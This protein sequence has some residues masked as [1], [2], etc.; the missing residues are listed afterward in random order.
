MESGS[1]WRRV[2]AKGKSAENTALANTAYKVGVASA[3]NQ[4]AANSASAERSA[5]SGQDN[6]GL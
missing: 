2:G 5:Q 6:T 4:A 1:S 3:R